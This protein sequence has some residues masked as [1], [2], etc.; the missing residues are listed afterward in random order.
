M[1]HNNRLTGQIP[2][3][4]AQLSR[5]VDILLHGNELSG[6]IPATFKE[7]P[8]LRRLSLS[9]NMLTGRIP[10]GLAT[11]PRLKVLFVNHNN[12]SGRVPADLESHKTLRHFAINDNDNLKPAEIKNAESQYMRL[13]K[14]LIDALAVNSEGYLASK[15]RYRREQVRVYKFFSH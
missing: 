2:G 10:K 14:R 8:Q 12:L 13:T 11:N 9:C 4:L 15:T 6:C 3:T 7:M 5:V 1:Q